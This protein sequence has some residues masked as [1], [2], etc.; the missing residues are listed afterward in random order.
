MLLCV[1]IGAVAADEPPIRIYLANDDH[2]DYFWTA[3]AETYD[4]TFADMLDF[5]LRLMDETADNPSPYQSRFNADGWFWLKSYERQKTPA[6]FERVIQRVRDGHL[7]VPLNAM[8]SCYGGQPAEA[9]LRGMYY[10][11]KLERK[12][13]L[14]IPLAVAMENN[15]LPLGLASLWAGAG[16]KY[17][18]RGVCACSPK[19]LSTEGLKHRDHEIYWYAGLD[20]QHVLMKWH[21]LASS[22]NKSI[23]GYAEAFN[24]AAAVEFLDSDA[25]F[26]K[27]Y[28]APGA[29]QPYAVRGAFGYGWDALGRK[30]GEPYALA[31]N[32]Y[33]ETDHFHEVAQAKSNAKRQV[34]VSNEADFF[35]DF[36]TEYGDELP[37][38]TVTHG[39]EWDL[40]SA[41]MAETSARVRRAVEQLRAAEA[42]ATMVSLHDPDFMR[43]RD[44]ARDDAFTGLGV[45]WEHNWTADGPVPRTVRAAWQNKVAAQ[46]EGYVRQLHDDA[47]ERLS[48]LIATHS[49][50]KRFFVFN[51]L[52]WIRTD[53]A[54]FAYTGEEDI[55]VHDLAAGADVPHQ[56]ITKSGTRHLRILAR[57]LP[58]VGYRVYEIRP[59]GGDAPRDVAATVNVRKGTIENS[60]I[61]LVLD[62]DGAIASF[63]DKTRGDVELAATIDGLKLNAFAAVRGQNKPVEVESTGPVSVTLRCES[64]SARKHVTRVTVY[65]DS[66]R[67]DLA[68]EITENF[69]DVRHWSFSFNLESPDVHCEEVGAIIRVKKKSEG[70]HYAD[71]NARYQYATLNHFCD[72]ADGVNQHGVTLSNWDC[73]FVRLGRSTP[74]ALDTETPQL[75]VLAGGQ[76][77]G[78]KLGIRNQNG[79]EYFLQRFA[80]NPH[81]SYDPVAAM[82]F[83]LEHQNPPVVGPVTGDTDAP[84]SAQEASLIR[85]SDPGVLLWSLKPAEEGI[86]HGVIARVWN[87][88]DSPVK[89]NVLFV[90]GLADARRVT[91]IETDL[92]PAEVHDSGVRT[93]LARQEMQTFRFMPS[94]DD[95]QSK[96][97]AA[98]AA[99]IS[100][101]E[102][103]LQFDARGEM[104]VSESRREL[105]V[106]PTANNHLAPQQYAKVNGHV[107]KEYDDDRGH[108]EKAATTET[109]HGRGKRIRSWGT[110]ALPDGGRLKKTVSVELYDRYPNAILFHTRYRNVGEQPIH[111][112]TLYE[113]MHRLAPDDLWA[114]HPRNWRWGE[115]FIF[116][117]RAWCSD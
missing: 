53:A 94:V 49:D 17:S 51:P 23:G 20:G 92:E 81:G 21:S 15:T 93:S 64:T 16:A 59:G 87:V 4:H 103:R 85:V 84:L 112:D 107:V 52:G 116:P 34:I 32:R 8:V 98:I 38:Q 86:N 77:D 71:R 100:H 117:V 105:M 43:G 19:V 36:E 95:A 89:A 70:G 5:H 37:S 13:D 96:R 35:Q 104:L 50:R 62:T 115:D 97:A 74:E 102:L 99:A 75:H 90:P 18:W 111:V 101:G 88:A 48:S 91:H 29:A 55:H 61:K 1:S 2:T 10:A 63:V 58:A 24:P 56:F 14:R 67:V 30:T 33:P 65:R 28:R 3:D 113:V 39:N 9:V 40:Y 82:K 6:E 44:A 26:L 31:P 83:A 60:R 76:V 109:V 114:F 106:A 12:Y 108:S 68:N 41:S 69:G 66:P 78:D 27:R 57:D 7:G 11:G 110:A 80:L 45:F 42:M 73:A 79:A 72:I 25:A 54:D 46:I 22:G 47:A